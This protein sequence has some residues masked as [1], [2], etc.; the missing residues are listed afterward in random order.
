[1]SGKQLGL[2]LW[3]AFFLF[4]TPLACG[5]AGPLTLQQ[6]YA[7]ALQ[8]NLEIR[9]VTAQRAEAQADVNLSRIRLNPGFT[10]DL[11]FISEKTYRVGGLI[12]PFEPPGK[13]RFRMQTAE[14]QYQ[15]ADYETAQK[16]HQILSQVRETYD[17]WVAGLANV[18]F[19]TENEAAL[20]L[21]AESAQKRF[22]GKAV[23]ELDV[24]QSG[25]L[26][27][28][29]EN[30]VEF[31]RHDLHITQIKLMYLLN[32]D[33]L[34]APDPGHF[35][36]L[37]PH[38]A[39]SLP[40]LMTLAESRRKDLKANEQAIEAETAR[41]KFFRV[42]RIPNIT[43]TSGFDM[44]SPDDRK[45]IGGFFLMGQVELPIFNHQQGNIAKSTAIKNRLLL[46]HDVLLQKI[47]QELEIAYQNL[48]FTESQ[49]KRQHDLLPLAD[50]VDNEALAEYLKGK[51]TINDV[52]G[53]HAN[54][55]FARQQ[56][57]NT[58]IAYQEAL[59]RIET[60]LTM[61]L[62]AGGDSASEP[63]FGDE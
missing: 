4:Y 56:A 6:A 24:N 49:W 29:A 59:S 23:D 25:M 36:R 44:V 55:Y 13:R 54:A 47:K 42:S 5:D 32:V 3:L 18:A 22:R 60:V 9:A 48:S 33:R 16:I 20:R 7:L 41:L 53:Q 1:M 57:L 19:E 14:H 34:Q 28:Q 52:L 63:A 15:Q 43:V 51:S 61:S 11:G 58:F 62:T 39:F 30:T 27:A 17:S 2:L 45:Y 46:E 35:D 31:A 37:A 40:E 8:N 26:L 10:T 38:E 21:I 50:T 12:M